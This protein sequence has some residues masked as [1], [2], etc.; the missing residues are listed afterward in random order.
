MRADATRNS[1]QGD[2]MPIDTIYREGG[3]TWFFSH[4]AS[5]GMSK[6]IPLSHPN[7]SMLRHILNYFDKGVGA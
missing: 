7:S 4:L 6:K 5:R 1:V 3:D 2:R